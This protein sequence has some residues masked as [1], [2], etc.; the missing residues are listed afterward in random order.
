MSVKYYDLQTNILLQADDFTEAYHRCMCGVNP[1]V[2]EYGCMRCHY[3]GVPA[4]VNAAFA[5]ELYLKYLIGSKIEGVSPQKRHDLKVLYS[6][7]DKPLQNQIREY[8]EA[9]WTQPDGYSFDDLLERAKNV[10]VA[11]RY[12]FEEEHTDGYMGC[13]INEY[14]KF[15]ELFVAILHKL[16]HENKETDEQ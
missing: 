6:K 1:E 10:F 9:Q 11:W 15:F 2:D 5:C 16:A 8:V 3:V 4:I 7:L 13:F 12:I 14:L